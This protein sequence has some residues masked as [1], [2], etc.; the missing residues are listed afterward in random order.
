[1]SR[2]MDVHRGADMALNIAAGALIQPELFADSLPVEFW[3]EIEQAALDQLDECD[4][5]QAALS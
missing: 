3:R 2:R 4:A 1:M 5:L